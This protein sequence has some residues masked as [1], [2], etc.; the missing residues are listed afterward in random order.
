MI[1]TSNTVAI[2]NGTKTRYAAPDIRVRA[3]NLPDTS[4]VEALIQAMDGE[5]VIGETLQMF[6]ATAVDGTTQLA[7]GYTRKFQGA[8]EEVVKG[9]LEG[10]TA[11]SGATF[12]IV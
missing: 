6:T 1:T 5:A 12:T 2:E 9:Y 4:Q 8:A 10:L 3:K 7:S 11:N